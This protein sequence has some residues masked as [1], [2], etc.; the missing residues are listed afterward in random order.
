MA[1]SIRHSLVPEALFRHQLKGK[2]MLL[3]VTVDKGVCCAESTTVVKGHKY[4]MLFL[5]HYWI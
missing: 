4:S 1:Y 2:K 3:Q 5:P